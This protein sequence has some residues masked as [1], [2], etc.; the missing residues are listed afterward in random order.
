MSRVHFNTPKM[1]H[2]KDT[3]QMPPKAT[4]TPAPL[5]VSKQCVWE[6]LPQCP[7]TLPQEMYSLSDLYSL[8]QNTQKPK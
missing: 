4:Q 1:C 6:D 5:S 7:H 3:N 2:P 8:L